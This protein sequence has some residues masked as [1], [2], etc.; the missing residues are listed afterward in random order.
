MNKEQYLEKINTSIKKDEYHITVVAGKG[1]LP[2]YVYT[3]GL[4][5]KIGFE[6]IFAGGEYYD[7]KQ[8]HIIISQLAK[9]IEAKNTHKMLLDLDSLG[10]FN[11]SE[12]HPSWIKKMMLGVY[13]Y[14]KINDFIAYQIKPDTDHFT[15]DIPD[16]SIEWNS[17]YQP[18]WKWLDQN[19]KWNL[20]VP[21]DSMVITDIDCL[22]GKKIIEVMRWEEDE[23]EAF[24]QN[25]EEISKENMR[26]IPI[27][28]LLG[29]DN[30]LQPILKLNI[31][32]G[33]WRDAENMEWNDWG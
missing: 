28:V 24:T 7:Y 31:G 23:W 16:M 5:K 8:I 12:A 9:M 18:I 13:D 6:L 19:I 29:T 3:I 14:Y 21:S 15:I 4:I 1:K 17:E 27:S 2:R 20:G 11:I 25:S 30:T 22:L 10:T 26:L 33:L 32:K